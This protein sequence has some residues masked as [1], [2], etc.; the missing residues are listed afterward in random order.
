[1]MSL[2]FVERPWPIR[3]CLIRDKPGGRVA[4]VV[5]GSH[6]VG[7]WGAGEICLPE[8]WRSRKWPFLSPEGTMLAWANWAIH[9]PP[10][11][12]RPLFSLKQLE[13]HWKEQRRRILE[14]TNQGKKHQW[15]PCLVQ[16]YMRHSGWT[17][18]SASK[19]KDQFLGENSTGL[20]R[21]KGSPY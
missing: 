10:S 11:L 4:C 13:S 12:C 1:M 15:Q 2:A 17:A 21:M 6:R 14:W 5:D 8:G 19:R 20:R 7:L 3:V 18:S 16:A 9:I